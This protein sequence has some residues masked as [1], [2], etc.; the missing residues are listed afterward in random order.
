MSRRRLG[1]TVVI[2][3]ACSVGVSSLKENWLSE[4]DLASMPYTRTIGPSQILL[5]QGKSTDEFLIDS[6]KL[7]PKVD[8]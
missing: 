1:A 3:M 6:N 7:K 5:T 4:T 8:E 2:L